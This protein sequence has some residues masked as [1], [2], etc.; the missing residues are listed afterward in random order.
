M[1]F[2]VQIESDLKKLAS[3][4]DGEVDYRA[5]D[6]AKLFPQ[7]W[8]KYFSQVEDRPNQVFPNSIAPIIVFEKNKSKVLPMRYRVR[9]HDSQEEVPSKYNLFNARRDSLFSR[10]TWQ[11]LLGKRHAI[12]PFTHFY[13]WVENKNGQKKLVRF[14]PV[15]KDIMWAAALTEHFERPKE[16]L[17]I[18]SFA[19]IT[20]EPPPEVLEAGHDRCPLFLSHQAAI[21]WM[22]LEKVSASDFDRIFEQKMPV[23]YQVEE[24]QIAKSKR[25]SMQLDLFDGE[26]F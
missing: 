2:S 20:D 19:L 8:P 9:P 5:F 24:V 16:A 25:P 11:N 26:D 15:G 12:F 21:E 23:K 10:K 1:C 18:D 6:E 13:E 17:V 22:K 14:S 4:F 3:L 7:K